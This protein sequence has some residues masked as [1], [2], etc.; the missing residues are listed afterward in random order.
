MSRVV[1]MAEDARAPA[2]IQPARHLNEKIGH[3]LS[4]WRYVLVCL[5][6]NDLIILLLSYILFTSPYDTSFVTQL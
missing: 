6:D 4:V 2:S 5:D 3:S 1:A